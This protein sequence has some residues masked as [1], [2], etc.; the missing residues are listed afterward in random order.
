MLSSWNFST[1]RMTLLLLTG[2]VLILVLVRYDLHLRVLCA[3]AIAE[4]RSAI[5]YTTPEQEEIAKKVTAE[6]QEK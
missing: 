6:V 3:D 4:Y 2:K 5:F 1:E